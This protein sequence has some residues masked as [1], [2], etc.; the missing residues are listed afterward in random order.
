VAD[1]GQA[2]DA[3]LAQALA[4]H[5][6]V[7]AM[8]EAADRAGVATADL[9]ALRARLSTQSARLVQASTRS[10]GALPAL[11]PT[12]TEIASAGPAL[13]DLSSTAV[14][15]AVSSMTATLDSVD[16]TLA[17]QASTAGAA[18]A[19]PQPVIPAAPVPEPQPVAVPVPSQAAPT[20]APP[21]PPPPRPAPPPPQPPAQPVRGV[22]LRNAG[23]YG[24]YSAAVLS[25]QVILFLVLDESR[26]LPAAAPVCLLVLPAMA[27]AAGYL[28]IGAIARPGPDGKVRH[29]PRLGLVICLIP[30]VLLFVWVGVLFLLDLGR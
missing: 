11:V 18:T 21:P 5:R 24:A 12:P 27:W 26:Q 23:I 17:E 16:V 25:V 15:T 19:P 7:A 1:I 29:A 4:W 8:V 9:P 3:Q 20:P 13:G 22:L 28:T 10:G 14:S 2:P 30:D 6:Q